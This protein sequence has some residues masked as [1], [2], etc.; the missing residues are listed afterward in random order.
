MKHLPILLLL[1]LG[2]GLLSAGI[3]DEE[4]ILE[5]FSKLIE[6]LQQNKL[7]AEP[8][9]WR[10]SL[11][12]FK[13]EAETVL[14]GQVNEPHLEHD[15]ISRESDGYAAVSGLIEYYDLEA[16]SLRLYH[17]HGAYIICRVMVDKHAENLLLGFGYNTCQDSCHV[18]IARSDPAAG[19]VTFLDA[20]NKP[21]AAIENTP[22]MTH[23]HIL[24]ELGI[25]LE[26]AAG[27][28]H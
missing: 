27:K 10:E 12:P 16:I 3:S 7:E 6:T 20:H 1:C 17:E 18:L 9:P 28:E 2:L 14:L 26:V 13:E 22:V 25:S 11:K 5:N 15:F 4:Y 23:K 24:H 19:G 21:L 8:G